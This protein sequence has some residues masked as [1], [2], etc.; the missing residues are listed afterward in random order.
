MSLVRRLAAAVLVSATPAWAAAPSSLTVKAVN[1]LDLARPS[2]TIELSAKDL[3][4]LPEKDL[5]KIHVTDAAGKELLCQAVDQDGDSKADQVLFQS[6]FAAKET[7]TFKVAGGARHT[8]KKEDFRAYG[9]FNR[10]RLDDFFWENDRVAHRMYGKALEV[11][12]AEGHTDIQVS[13]AVDVW[14]KR[15]PRLVMNEWYMV[16]NYHADSGEG[17]DYYSA[18]DTRGVGGNGLWAQ[19]KMWLS[20]NFVQSQVFASG[21]IRVLFELSYEP[22]NVERTAVSETKRISLD[23]GQNFVRFE[24]RYKPAGTATLTA[25]LGIRKAGP[26]GVAVVSKDFDPAGGWLATWEPVEKKA[27]SMGAAIVV[28]PKLVERLAE[29]EKNLL[30]IAK[31]PDLKLGYWAGSAWDKAGHFADYAAWKSHVEAFARG[32]QSPIEVTVSAQ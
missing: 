23:A 7:K 19:E 15:T 31:V 24:S 3:A 11:K 27:G 26:G 29:D 25:A 12:P 18:G 21:P 14:M 20:R 5:K 30:V 6:D 1:T 10:E 22:I 28:D 32:L 8:Y 4:A 13:S 17:A 2:Q 16:D 9:R